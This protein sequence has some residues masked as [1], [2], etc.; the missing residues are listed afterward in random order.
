MAN[1][2]CV[3]AP[4]VDVAGAGIDG[5]DKIVAARAGSVRVDDIAGTAPLV[6]A[7]GAVVAAAGVAVVAAGAGVEPAVAGADAEVA[8]AGV[9][10]A[11]ATDAATVAAVG[12]VVALSAGATLAGVIDASRAGPGRWMSDGWAVLAEGGGSSVRVWAIQWR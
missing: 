2:Q 5:T 3:G 10:A 6:A 11:V 4:A 9:E 8:G 1:C 7:A 12:G